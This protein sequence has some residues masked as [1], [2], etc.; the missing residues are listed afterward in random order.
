[1]SRS[2]ESRERE[3]LRKQKA[4]WKTTHRTINAE[5]EVTSERQVPAPTI[6]PIVIPGSVPKFT[7]TWYDREGNPDRQVVRHEP[8]RAATEAA[9]RTLLDEMRQSLALVEPVPY[10]SLDNF[11]ASLMTAYPI[12]DHHLGMLSWGAETGADYD[13]DIGELL[14]IR[15]MANLTDRAP[16]SAVGLI[17]I[18]G[19][20]F[21]YDSMKSITPHGGNQLDSDTRYRKMINVG[22]RVIQQAI[23]FALKKH[24]SVHVVAV[25]GNHDEVGINWL[26]ELLDA[27]YENEPR[28]TI[29]TSPRV[30]HY[31]H[32]GKNLIGIVHGDRNKLDSLPLMMAKDSPVAWGQTEY[33]TW[34]TGHVHSEK[35]KEIMGVIVETFGIL[36]P[37]DAWSVGQGYRA[38]RQMKAITYHKE[39]GEQDRLT[40][41]PY[42]MEGV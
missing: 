22:R 19:D 37:G 5:G 2:A 1:M 24:Q 14:L 18:L 26:A 23:H 16:P 28:V 6:Q 41:N 7:T 4:A 40:T 10:P 11:G 12:G 42:M 38:R 30:A 3:R 29:D 25:P 33:R 21:H 32:F 13:L 15:A 35:V 36:P 9:W 27:V 20:F 17:V 8:Q 39:F 34:F 31:V